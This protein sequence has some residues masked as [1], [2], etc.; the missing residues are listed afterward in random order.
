[1]LEST[2]PDIHKNNPN[3]DMVRELF[4]VLGSLDRS[5][6]AGV[7]PVDIEGS[8]ALGRLATQDEI[9]RKIIGLA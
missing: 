9:C 1:M 2:A 8:T 6:R 4:A 3:Q 7:I 5:G